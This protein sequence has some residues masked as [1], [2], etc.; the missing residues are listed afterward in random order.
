MKNLFVFTLAMTLFVQANAVTPSKSS[1]T[2]IKEIPVQDAQLQQQLE[3][4]VE[5]EAPPAKPQS[6]V[7]PAAVDELTLDDDAQMSDEVA[8]AE[9]QQIITHVQKHKKEDEKNIYISAVVGTG[10]YP[11]VNNIT[12]SYSAALSAGYI[13][14]NMIMFEGGIGLTRY[15]MDVLNFSIS[16]RRDNYEIDQYS[17]FVGAKYRILEGRIVPT[18]GGLISYTYRKFA[19]TNPYMATVNTGNVDAGNSSTTD[20][21]I[22]AG[23]DYEFSR[24]FAVGVDFKYM[25]NLA[26]SKDSDSNN[27]NSPS[28]NGYAGTSIERLQYYTAGVSARMNF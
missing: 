26:N 6:S 15:E 11:D 4:E 17:A 28:F 8:A 21:G 16:N 27:I 3:K 18:V 13:Y 14:K 24:D 1:S 10:A 2:Q 23:L 5:A 22:T 19:L 12:G 9:A 25:M 7:T 20:G